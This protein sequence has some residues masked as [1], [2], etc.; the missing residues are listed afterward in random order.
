MT[1]GKAAMGKADRNGGVVKAPPPAKT[2]RFIVLWTQNQQDRR[3]APMSEQEAGNF[4]ERLQRE[5]AA[6]VRIEEEP[7]VALRGVGRAM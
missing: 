5:K 4:A 3:S 7:K 6:T 2:K 1:Q